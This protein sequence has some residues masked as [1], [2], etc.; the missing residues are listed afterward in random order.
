MKSTSEALPD[1]TG[2]VSQYE[3]GSVIVVS[4]VLGTL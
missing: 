3:E 4:K 1:G 2:T